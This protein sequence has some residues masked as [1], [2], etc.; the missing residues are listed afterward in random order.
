MEQQIDSSMDTFFGKLSLSTFLINEQD[1]LS[2]FSY[3]K[4]LERKA[5]QLLLK[6]L[7][8][9]YKPKIL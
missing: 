3:V 6:V 8:L 9:G 1:T 2:A 4:F 5:L 7:I